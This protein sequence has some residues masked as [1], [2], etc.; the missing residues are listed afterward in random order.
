[1]MTYAADSNDAGL[2]EGLLAAFSPTGSESGAVEYLVGWMQAHGFQARADPAGNAVG[3]RGDGPNNIVLLGHIDTVPGLIPVRRDGDLLYGRG[4]VDAKGPLACFA[5]SAAHTNPGPEWRITVI[6]A[7]AEEGDSHGARFV[8]ERYQPQMAVIGEP[9]SWDHLTLGYKGSLW[10][11]YTLQRPMV[12]TSARQES[13]CEGAVGFWN[14][15]E[16]E[17]KIYN[18][19]KPKVFEQFTPTLRQMNSSTDGFSETATLTIGLRLPP[20][21]DVDTVTSVLCSLAGEGSLS[22]E[23]GAIPAYR[24]DKNNPLVRAFLSAIRQAG[25]VPGFL[26]KSG[27][28]DMNIVG[29]AWNCPILAYGPGDSNLDHTPEEHISLAEYHL[30]VQVLTSVLQSI[31]HQRGPV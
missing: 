13:A 15:L 7:V 28:A 29:P 19:D 2:L 9:S 5:A 26:V 31:T 23:D 4:S 24:A 18:A 21:R 20:E 25:G 6:G 30:G 16:A 14:R 12:H 27:T 8:V 11:K 10:A 1:M 22:F 3:V 17:A